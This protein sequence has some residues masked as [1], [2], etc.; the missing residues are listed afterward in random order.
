MLARDVHVCAAGLGVPAE[1]AG[2][3][4][5]GYDA[6][7]EFSEDTLFLEEAEGKVGF[8]VR[9][10]GAEGGLGGCTGV[11]GSFGGDEVVRG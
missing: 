2:A 6:F 8:C 10:E 4:P 7:F 1:A 9:G 11:Y 3:R 5:D